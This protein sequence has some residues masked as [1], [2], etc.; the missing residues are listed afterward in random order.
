MQDGWD[1]RLP[2]K[3]NC[4]QSSTLI[5]Y[6]PHQNYS[7]NPRMHNF[8][9]VEQKPEEQNEIKDEIITM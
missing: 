8:G 9:F 1:L 2:F 4:N 6:W 3:K 5:W 7:N